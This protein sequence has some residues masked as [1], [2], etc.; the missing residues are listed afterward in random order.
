MRAKK[1]SL[2]TGKLDIQKSTKYLYIL[3]AFAYCFFPAWILCVDHTSVPP[4]MSMEPFLFL[5]TCAA[6]NIGWAWDCSLLV[7][8]DTC[9]A[10]MQRRWRRQSRLHTQIC[11]SNWTPRN[12]V[13]KP[14]RSPWWTLARVS[15]LWKTQNESD[16]KKCAARDSVVPFNVSFKCCTYVTE[17]LI[18]CL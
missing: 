13:A 17:Y 11:A 18:V 12:L 8:A 6:Q 7:K 2:N 9:I 1:L 5:T 16:V 14:L 4:I 15:V 3:S 10:G